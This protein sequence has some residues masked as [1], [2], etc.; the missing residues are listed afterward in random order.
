MATTG[1]TRGVLL[2]SSQRARPTTAF[3]CTGQGAQ[4]RGMAS[5][6]YKTQPAF[7]EALDAC[8]SVLD[9]LLEAPLLEMIFSEDESDERINQTGNTQ[10]A[11]FAVEYALYKLLEASGVRPDVVMGHSVGEFTA[12]VIAGVMTLEDGAKLIC[13]RG[14][15]MQELPSGGGM[16]SVFADEADTTCLAR[17]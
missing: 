16:L 5:G 9:P 15:L 12:A 14:R 4:Y 2:S 1:Q 6:L 7:Q 13:A 17:F 3:L 10:P 11:L 8:A